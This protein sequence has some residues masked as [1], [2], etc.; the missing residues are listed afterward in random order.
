ML[1]RGDEL[2]FAWT[3]PVPKSRVRAGALPLKEIPAVD[4]PRNEIWTSA[5]RIDLGELKA[6]DLS[7][8]SVSLARTQ[9]LVVMLSFW[10][11]TCEQCKKDVSLLNVVEKKYRKRGLALIAIN[12]DPPS[13]EA[14]ARAMAKKLGMRY[15]VWRAQSGTP[16]A[17]TPLP[18]HV[19]LDSFR[20]VRYQHHGALE[21][22]LR[23]LQEE[24]EGLL[25]R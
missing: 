1:R 4:P 16:P 2:I 23:G 11:T 13:N 25:P 17:H 22:N 20:R 12:I 10:S 24:L 18:L 8:R 19:L 9:S 7:G 3:E 14:R 6:R 21:E 15:R 5:G